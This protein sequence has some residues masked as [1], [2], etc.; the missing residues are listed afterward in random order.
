LHRL[1]SFCNVT[2]GLNRSE[3]NQVC[4]ALRLPASSLHKN[5]EQILRAL[6]LSTVVVHAHSEVAVAYARGTSV[7]SAYRT[8]PLIKH[9]ARSTGAG[10]TFNAGY[11]AGMLSQLPPEECLQTAVAASGAF[12]K[13]GR[14]PTEKSLWL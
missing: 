6:K 11:I 12:V 10:D 8:V 14:P 9:P 2:L 1:S 13:T 3:S 4:A 7:A 5:A